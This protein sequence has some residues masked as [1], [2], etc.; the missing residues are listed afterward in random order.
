MPLDSVVESNLRLMHDL[1][2]GGTR[3]RLGVSARRLAPVCRPQL[4]AWQRC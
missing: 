4:A 1:R 2:Q 3:G